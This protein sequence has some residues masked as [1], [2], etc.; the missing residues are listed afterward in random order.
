VNDLWLSPAEIAALGSAALPATKQAVNRLAESEGWA[1]HTPPRHRERAGRGGGYEYH[2]SLLPAD[3]QAAALR[4]HFAAPAAA[5]EEPSTGPWAAFEAATQAQ[6]AEAER[7]LAA[8]A[9][10]EQLA[11]GMERQLAVA[12][13]AQAHGV[14]RSTLWGWLA[15]AAAA[16]RTDRLA[17]LL[18]GHRGGGAKREID[19]RAW[20]FLAGDYLRPE[21]P[22]IAACLRRLAAAAAAQGWGPLPSARTLRRRLAAL[23]R[24]VTV[25]RREGTDAAERLYPAQRRSRAGLAAMQVLN[26]DGHRFDVFVQFEDGTVG[27]PVI[28]AFQDIHSGKVLSWRIDRSEHRELVRLAFAD[29][30]ER[31]GIPD[32]VVFDNG[33]QFAS[34][35]LTGRMPV[36][37]RFKVKDEEPKGILTAL[38]VKVV[39]TLPYRGQSKQIERAFRDF[40]EDIA[41]HPACAGAYTGNRPD[42]KPEN[43]G[44]RAVPIADFCALVE[45]EIAA[46]NAR[47]GRRGGVANGRSFDE[48]FATS[49][50]LP[51]TIIK[52]ASPAQRRLLLLAVEGVTARPPTGEIH[53][54]HN[55]YHHPA[56]VEVAGRRVA[57]RFD[58]QALR[59][60]VHVYDL[61]GRYLCEAGC[62]DDSGF[63]DQAEARVHNRARRAYAKAAK[64]AAAAESA[65]DIADIAEMIAAGM[66]KP[67]P[68]APQ[69]KTVRLV[70]NG[71]A[72][73]AFDADAF[74]RAVEALSGEVLPFP[75]RRQD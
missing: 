22:G 30:V 23:P 41:K 58:P 29:A 56:L 72:V 31:Y 12:L 20:A 27:R 70:A 13:A 10:A 51:T 40:C 47:T 39:W 14:A 6:K 24:A 57:V 17:A 7:R 50:A 36:R 43:Y 71:R 53:L 35:W 60:P 65:L 54:E 74:G 5:V 62:I 32:T 73:P 37:F 49:M 68:P 8:V 75:A 2:V 21:R 9:L 34:K 46:H 16:E 55:R 45:R 15:R 11:S 64:L 67:A 48:V 61:D 3:A 19:P 52:R 26:A 59:A 66:P 1:K 42:A 4:R 69:S 63:R 38:G 25:V 28:L 44:G 33:R 18:P